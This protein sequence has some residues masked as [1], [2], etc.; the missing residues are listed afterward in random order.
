MMADAADEHEYLYVRRREGLYFAGLGFAGKAA[1]GLGVMLAGVGLDLV[2]F[3]RDIGRTVGAVLPRDVQSH[4]V[5][6]W[7]PVAA[8]I[9]VISLMILAGYSINRAR[10]DEIAL[11]LGRAGGL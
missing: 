10:H 1:T 11:A 3:P 9:A 6:I 2:H 4:L 8:V 7:G 5:M